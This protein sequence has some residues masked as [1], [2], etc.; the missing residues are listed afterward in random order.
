MA[1]NSRHSHPGQ[2]HSGLSKCDRS[3]GQPISA[4]PAHNSL[5]PPWNSDPD[6]RDVGN[7]NSGHVCHSSQHASSPVYVSNPGASS[8][9]QK[10][11]ATQDG[12]VI[13]IAPWWPSQPWFP[14][15]LH[16]YVDY[17]LFFPY[18]WDLLSQQGYVLGGCHAALP[19]SRIFEEVSRL[20][21]APGKPST[22]RVYDDKWLH[23][24]HWA[25]GQGIDALG[26]T[27]AQIAAFLYYLF[28]T[29]GLSP[30]SIKGY[31]SCLAS[32]VSGTGMTAA[33]QAKTMSDMIYLY[34]VTEA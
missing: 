32:V 4:E 16:L 28:D 7:S 14:H 5:S 26:P 6:L 18:R 13:L 25:T 19:N 30:Q 3:S 15:L 24:P 29:Q 21:A 1:T 23:F 8:T 22:N 9:G 17:P 31:R 34:G 12:E 20:A 11:R 10:V 33:V 27:A 2:T